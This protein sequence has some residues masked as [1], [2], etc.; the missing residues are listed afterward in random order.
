MGRRIR[1][2]FKRRAGAAVV[3]WRLRAQNPG[4]GAGCERAQKELAAHISAHHGLGVEG[5][6][7]R[8]VR[9]QIGRILRDQAAM[10]GRLARMKAALA[11]ARMAR[12]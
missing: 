8:Q 1:S 3:D 6:D 7:S 4:K 9:R 5:A 12:G 2:T 11:D 10:S